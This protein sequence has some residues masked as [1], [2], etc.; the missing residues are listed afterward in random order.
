MIPESG[1]RFSD[2]I[3]LKIGQ[4]SILISSEPKAW[5]GKGLDGSA[6]AW[7]IFRYAI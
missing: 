3:M 6:V 7:P 2:K 4:V 1:N 5:D